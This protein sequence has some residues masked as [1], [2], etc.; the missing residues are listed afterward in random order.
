MEEGQLF[1]F[2]QVGMAS[3]FGE[4]LLESC[5]RHHGCGVGGRMLFRRCRVK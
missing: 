3:D 1:F 4:I 5:D 2:G